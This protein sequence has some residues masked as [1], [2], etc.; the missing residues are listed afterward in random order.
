MR[1]Q[2]VEGN[3]L[4]TLVKMVRTR[5]VG[6]KAMCAKL[7]VDP[8]KLAFDAVAFVKALEALEPLAKQWEEAADMY[9]S[10]T[11]DVLDELTEEERKEDDV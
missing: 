6:A 1:V 5:V 11:E 4:S 2:E 3:R 7:G 8:S 10:E 9:D